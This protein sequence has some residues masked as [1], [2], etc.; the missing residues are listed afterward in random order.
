MDII[1][2]FIPTNT[3]NINS[4]TRVDIFLNNDK[5]LTTQFINILSIGSRIIYMELNKLNKSIDNLKFNY[6]GSFSNDQIKELNKIPDKI[7]EFTTKS[8]YIQQLTFP[9]N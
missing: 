3:I 4:L 7:K 1:I 5:I 6:L 9:Y 2:D 8:S